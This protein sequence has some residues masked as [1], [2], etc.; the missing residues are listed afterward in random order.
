MTPTQLVQ[1]CW[2]PMTKAFWICSFRP[3]FEPTLVVVMSEIS[4]AAGEQSTVSALD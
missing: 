3:D 4:A 1:I 2:I